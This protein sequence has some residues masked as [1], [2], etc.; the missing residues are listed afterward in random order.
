M[1]ADK[2]FAKRVLARI[3]EIEVAGQR[4][5]EERRDARLHAAELESAEER[6]E[7]AI[8]AAQERVAVAEA[9]LR[10][11]PDFPHIDSVV[12]AL[13]DVLKEDA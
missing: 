8:A 9:A 12:Q 6:D 11:A 13:Y 10:P 2:S 4:A 5:V 3:E 7:D 1:A